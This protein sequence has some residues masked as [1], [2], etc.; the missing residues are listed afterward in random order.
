MHVNYSVAGY[1]VSDVIRMA[2]ELADVV[3]CADYDSTASSRIGV[4]CP[5]EVT[6]NPHVSERSDLYDR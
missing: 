5:K 2:G 4:S 3:A 6:V 1:V